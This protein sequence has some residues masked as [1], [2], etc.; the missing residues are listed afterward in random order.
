[1]FVHMNDISK[2]PKRN[3][4]WQHPFPSAEDENA[5]QKQAKRLD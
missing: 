3:G 5:C 2:R 1:M 4:I